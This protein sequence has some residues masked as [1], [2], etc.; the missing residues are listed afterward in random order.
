M[1][2]RGALMTVA[3]SGAFAAA[4][5]LGRTSKP[6]TALV[7]TSDFVAAMTCGTPLASGFVMLTL[8]P[9]FSSLFTS[10]ALRAPLYGKRQDLPLATAESTYLGAA[11][12]FSTANAAGNS[13]L[14]N[15]VFTPNCMPS[16]QADTSYGASAGALG[17]RRTSG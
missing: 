13:V 12:T 11:V 3:S 1:P 16:D 17:A 7:Q 9:A 8:A 15:S 6:S 5:V 4:T 10:R 14:A 2:I